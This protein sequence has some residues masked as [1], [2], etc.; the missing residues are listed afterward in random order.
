MAEGQVVFKESQAKEWKKYHL[1]TS[2]RETEEERKE[3]RNLQF[4]ALV[5]KSGAKHYGLPADA[6]ERRM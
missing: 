1:K 3:G 5:I 6:K 4:G 2:Q